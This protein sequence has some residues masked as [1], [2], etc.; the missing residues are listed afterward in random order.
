[1]PG[2]GRARS[3]EPC[4]PDPERPHE[5]RLARCVPRVAQPACIRRRHAARRHAGRPRHARPRARRH[6]RG[7]HRLREP[8]R[9]AHRPRRQDELRPAAR[10]RLV[11]GAGQQGAHPHAARRRHLPGR[12]ENG[13]GSR[14]RQP[15]AR[16]HRARERAQGRAEAGLRHRGGG[17]AHRAAG[18]LAALCAAARRAR[19][20]RRHDRLAEGGGGEGRA[21]RHRAGLRRPVLLR[22]AR[23][24]GPDHAAALCRLLERGGDRLRPRDLHRR[25]PTRRCG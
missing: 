18:A 12:H 5:P 16:A 14:A 7:P 17:P 1:M 25:S 21:I 13:R 20:P 4:R 11:V 9:Q 6:L 23:G 8:L 3:G 24:A 15:G 19:G 22:L 2:C 10:D